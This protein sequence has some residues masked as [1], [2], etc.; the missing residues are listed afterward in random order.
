MLARQQYFNSRQGG[1]MSHFKC[2]VCGFEVKTHFSPTLLHICKDGQ[3]YDGVSSRGLGDTVAKM[4]S[5][6]GIKKS[7]N[8]KCSQRQDKLNKLVPY[9]SGQ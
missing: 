5:S 2:N 6:V 3:P 9:K 4:L 7:K 1:L 8:C